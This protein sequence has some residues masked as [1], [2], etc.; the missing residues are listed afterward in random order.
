[1]PVWAVLILYKCERQP[2]ASWGDP[3][4]LGYPINSSADDIFYHP[5]TD[6]LVALIASN[7][8]GGFGGLD[9]YEVKKDPRI[10]FEIWGEVTDINDGTILP[11]RM[12]IID[13]T[14]NSPVAYAESDS[15]SGEYYIQMEDVGHYAIQADVTGYKSWR[16]TLDM[17][18]KRHE[19]IRRDFQLEK[20]LF[21]YTLWGN[22]TNEA[23]GY[24]VQ[25][26]ILIKSVNDEVLINSGY[27][28]ENTGYY[29]ITLADK[30]NVLVEVSADDFYGKT[31][32]LHKDK[33]V[34]DNG[35]LNIALTSSK[36][37][38]TLTGVVSDEVSGN[39]VPAAIA[40]FEPGVMEPVAVAYADSYRVVTR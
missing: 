17:P 7:R 24:P 37:V 20:L 38:F 36:Q 21:P 18:E 32:Q 26:E 1:M 4:N 31:L 13:L 9:I 22:I 27:S 3:V 33:M 25:A 28:S 11:A 14:E 10:P 6:S 12:T 16:D 15:L 19:K 40:A 8:K 34:G 2:D 23:N 30:A 29:S 5:T 39:P 35:E